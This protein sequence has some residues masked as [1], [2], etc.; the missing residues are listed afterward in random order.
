MTEISHHSSS[1]AL[2]NDDMEYPTWL[3]GESQA[4]DIVGADDSLLCN[5]VLDYNALTDLGLNRGPFTGFARNTNEVPEGEGNA[6]YNIA[7]LENLELDTPPDFHLTV[8][9]VPCPILTTISIIYI[10]SA[11]L[12]PCLQDLQFG[13]QDSILDWLDWL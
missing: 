9:I 6:I 5:E 4:V 10:V 1:P 3:A 2:I 13:S 8:S 12:Y 7:D 11:T